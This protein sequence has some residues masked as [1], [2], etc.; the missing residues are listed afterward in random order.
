MK[1]LYLLFVTGLLCFSCTSKPK[2]Q[3]K[4]DLT[5]IKTDTLDS[6]S[7]NSE[8]R[9]IIK[10]V[11]TSFYNWYIRTT[12]AEYDTTKAFSFIIVEGENGKCKTD[13]EPYFRQL[14]QLGTISKR[15]MDKEIER[16]KTCIDHMKTVD[17]NEYKNSEPYTY[18]DF[19]PDCSYMYWFQSQE[20]FDGIEIVDM[21]K[22]EN[23]WYTTLW[24]YID[25]Q[26]KRTHYDSPRPIVKIEN[27]NGK[28]LT[29]EIELK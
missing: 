6:K 2:T 25:S 16:N 21:T 5:P 19:C 17:W 10:K 4:S 12:K 11:S 15:F 9:E 28:W 1:K 22:K 23:I 26:N 27:E 7:D 13:F 14:R 24:F 3:E 20:S 29:T 18:E 8:E